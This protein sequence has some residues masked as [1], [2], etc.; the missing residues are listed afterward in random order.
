MR[1]LRNATIALSLGGAIA[2]TSMVPLG[3]PAMAAP[4][5]MNAAALTEAAPS[6]VIEVR[7]RHRHR[8]G[9]IVAGLAL[10][11]IGSIIAHEAYRRHYRR[12]YYPYGYYE[13]YPRCIRRHGAW[14][15]R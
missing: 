4:L 9:A 1:R 7:R 6:D 5:S 11:V 2:A 12:H 8:S 15:C 3:A 14:Y 10:G 13:P